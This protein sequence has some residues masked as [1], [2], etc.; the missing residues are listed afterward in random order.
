VKEAAFR[1]RETAM[2]QNGYWLAQITTFDQSGWPL[3]DIPN[4][5][6]LISA[7]TIQDL[8]KAAIK[9]LRTDN[10]VRVSLY[11]EN[12]PAAGNK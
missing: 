8:Q 9:Y 12:F 11:P 7:L 6:K 1:S 5:E 10:Y 4:G 2:K 3:A